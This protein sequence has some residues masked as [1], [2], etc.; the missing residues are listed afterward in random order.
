MPVTDNNCLMNKLCHHVE[1]EFEGF[2]YKRI[3]EKDDFDYTILMSK[4]V[5]CDMSL[6][7]TINNLIKSYNSTADYQIRNKTTNKDDNEKERISML[8]F[9]KNEI[10]T[11]IK[12]NKYNR[13]I[14]INTFI[15][16]IYSNK[17]QSKQLLWDI[18][19]EEIID[20]LIEVNKCDQNL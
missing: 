17:K 6:H 2:V 10:E 18:F 3:S 14:F 8:E 9:Y 15:H 12:E 16:I 13:N 20:N 4:N 19:S 1:K 11:I 7:D 5:M